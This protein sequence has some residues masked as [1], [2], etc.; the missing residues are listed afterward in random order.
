[1]R[2]VLHFAGRLARSIVLFRT[3]VRKTT[4]ITDLA[5]CF[6]CFVLRMDNCAR[7]VG[8]LTLYFP[9]LTPNW[10]PNLFNVHLFLPCAKDFV[11]Q[12]AASI[13][14]SIN[15]FFPSPFGNIIF[16]LY[17]VLYRS[18]CTAKLP[19]SIVHELVDRFTWEIMGCNQT[20][21]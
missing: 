12:V 8:S 16:P 2:H 17:L 20:R 1:M 14:R 21:F 9:H 19:L 7:G 11:K 10:I 5:E 4:Y 3:L 15:V 6:Q 18:K 13:L